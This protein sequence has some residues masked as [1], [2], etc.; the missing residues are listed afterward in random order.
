MHFIFS[1]FKWIWLSGWVTFFLLLIS[2]LCAN[3]PI[4]S[5]FCLAAQQ[6]LLYRNCGIS[7]H[8]S[9]LCR[10][11][12]DAGHLRDRLLQKGWEGPAACALDV[13]RIPQRRCLYHHV[14]C[15]VSFHLIRLLFSNRSSVWILI[16]PVWI[17]FWWSVCF[18][19]TEFFKIYVY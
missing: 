13:S 15:V 1:Q 2:K 4:S 7:H 12:H 8:L 14:W 17:L 3:K 11:W 16:I 6:A 18:N 9:L 19:R 5:M 10:F